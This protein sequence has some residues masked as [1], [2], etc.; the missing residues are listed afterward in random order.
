MRR[1]HPETLGD[2]DSSVS[3]PRY[4]YQ[5]VQAG[6]VHLGLGAFHRAH[7][8]VYTEAAMEKNGGNW[9]IIGV[10]LRSTTVFEQLAPQGYLYS[11]V[12]E[13]AQGQA[14][15][16]IGAIREVLVAPR[17]PGRV[18]AAIANPDIALVTLTVTEKGYCLAS[19]GCSLNREDQQIAHDLANPLQPASA[20][21]ILALG[22]QQRL[23]QGGAPLTV[24]S[25]D[26][27]ISNSKVLKGVLSDYL[28]S[29]FPEVLPW[30]ENNTSFPC[31]MVDRIVPASTPRQKQNHALALG[32]VDEGA[33]F[34]EPFSQWVIED[35][36]CAGRPAWE[37]VGAQL[38]E[39]V[40]P[41]EGIKLRLLNATHS[42]IAYCGLVA[43]L[44][45]VDQVMTDKDISAF[46]KELMAVDLIPTLHI[47]ETFDIYAYSD[48]LLTR[49]ANP[50]L[51]HRCSQI[52]M[53][54]CEKISQ[55]WLPTF[56]AAPNAGFLC[57]ALSTWCYFILHTEQKIDD[58]KSDALYALR[59]SPQSNESRLP[60]LLSHARMTTNNMPDF[61]K[62]CSTVVKQMSL[63]DARGMIALLR[64]V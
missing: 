60:A 48:Q 38:V 1:L 35:R 20:V 23:A 6:I 29:S 26:N 9:G 32:V 10:S 22:L 3:T 24:L 2:V 56:Q 47:P 13:D 64:D 45:T 28:Q 40:I 8:A 16:I 34:T 17:D 62:L 37:A 25:C 52:A 55:R 14:S 49:L 31:S 19:D 57:K 51:N 21:G 33:V 58:P 27:L 30:L 44:K 59:A 42:A 43:G 7:Q 15:Q 5:Q 39:D 41:Y 61:A 53:D 36:F 11:V 4:D 50:A 63:I 46:V 18:A 54:G 12:S